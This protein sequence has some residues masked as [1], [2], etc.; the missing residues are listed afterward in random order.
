MFSVEIE[1]LLLAGLCFILGVVA[2]VYCLMLTTCCMA[3]K[4]LSDAATNVVPRNGRNAQTGVRPPTG[5]RE[6]VGMEPTE[7]VR[8]PSYVR[9]ATTANACTTS[10]IGTRPEPAQFT[11]VRADLRPSERPRKT[12]TRKTNCGP[13]QV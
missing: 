11:A 1:C 13:H 10:G 3:N 5:N 6:L 2:T 8:R 9:V 4:R 7:S 12:D